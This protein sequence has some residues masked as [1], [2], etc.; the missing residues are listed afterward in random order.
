MEII[1]LLN[2]FVGLLGGIAIGLWLG[3]L[4]NWWKNLK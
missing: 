3:H 1:E 2:M 4:I